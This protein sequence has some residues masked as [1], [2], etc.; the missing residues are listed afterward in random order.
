MCLSTWNSHSP[1]VRYFLKL[2]QG[3]WNSYGVVQIW[4]CKHL[5]SQVVYFLL[6]FL[7]K[8]S[9][10]C[11]CMYILPCL[12]AWMPALPVC[13]LYLIYTASYFDLWPS[14]RRKHR[15]WPWRVPMYVFLFNNQICIILP[16][17]GEFR[18]HRQMFANVSHGYAHCM[19]NYSQHPN[20]LWKTSVGRC[21]GVKFEYHHYSKGGWSY[22]SN[23]YQKLEEKNL[24]RI[25]K[26]FHHFFCRGLACYI[27]NIHN[28]I[29]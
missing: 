17:D 16:Q 28:N 22:I 5:Y 6:P 18:L 24:K 2:P 13:L 10:F 8:F 19:H 20:L 14:C 12:P 1:C 29:C 25:F 11:A 21:L 9:I 23:R 3:V 4:C 7:S 15:I 26:L 27:H